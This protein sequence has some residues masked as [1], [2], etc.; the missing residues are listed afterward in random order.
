MASEPWTRITSLLHHVNTT[1]GLGVVT[2]VVTVVW[3]VHRK[4]SRPQPP[5]PAAYI[6]GIGHLLMLSSHPARKL[7]K[8][9]QQYG[10]VFKLYMG[11][12][13]VIIVSGFDVIN[14]ILLTRG[15]EFSNRPHSFL[16]EK[17]AHNKGLLNTSGEV[18]VEQRKNVVKTIRSLAASGGPLDLHIKKATERLTS[19]LKSLIEMGQGDNVDIFP[20]IKQCSFFISFSLAY[21]RQPDFESDEFINYL[22]TY[23]DFF[24]CLNLA[25]LTTFIPWIHLV[26]G[27]P[28][29]YRKCET[30]AENIVHN[31]VKPEL[32]RLKKTVTQPFALV[33]T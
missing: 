32:N 3:L 33:T 6:P 14:E 2:V 22:K 30:L 24:R 15:A 20:L 29:K 27:D 8:L 25:I 12:Y 18:W 19:Q 21:G 7:R 5:G 31:Y 10:D 26:P 16:A 11:T 4:F 13:P 28:V 1:V 23:D 9:R 17:L